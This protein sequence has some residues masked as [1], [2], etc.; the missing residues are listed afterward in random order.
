MPN[1]DPKAVAVNAAGIADAFRLSQIEDHDGANRLEDLTQSHEGWVGVVVQI[2]EAA[3]IMERYRVS[4]GPN[5]S[6]GGELPYLYEV[7]DSIARTL[8][9]YLDSDELDALVRR[10]IVALPS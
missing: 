3:E 1:I 2:S 8:W 4:Q 6:W 7:W 5:A 9:E 10:A